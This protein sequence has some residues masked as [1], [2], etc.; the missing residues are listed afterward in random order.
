[1]LRIPIEEF[2]ISQFNDDDVI[3]SW[4]WLMS[5]ISKRAWEKRKA[6]I[7]HNMAIEFQDFNPLPKSLNEGTLVVIKDDVIGWYLYLVKTLIKEPHKY[8]YFQGARI[9]PIFKRLGIDLDI[10]KNIEGIDIRVKDLLY[11]RKSEADALLFEILTALLWARN[12]YQ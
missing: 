3:K 4:K 7:E 12:G 1:M 2:P 5:F 10:L 8:E 6:S 11:K 9:I